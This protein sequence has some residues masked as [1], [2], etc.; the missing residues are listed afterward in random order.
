[1][2]PMYGKSSKLVRLIPTMEQQ[3]QIGET[4]TTKWDT[5]S[6]YPTRLYIKEARQCNDTRPPLDRIKLIQGNHLQQRRIYAFYIEFC[7]DPTR[8]HIEERQ[9]SCSFLYGWE[10]ANRI[11]GSVGFSRLYWLHE[12]IGH[13]AFAKPLWV[14]NGLGFSI[15]WEF[16]A[17]VLALQLVSEYWRYFSG[18]IHFR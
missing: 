2:A 15:F 12:D 16:F 5:E 14:G 3:R 17:A 18:Y 8:W 13:T 1:M 7:G 9:C 11:C 6:G 10:T 4:Y